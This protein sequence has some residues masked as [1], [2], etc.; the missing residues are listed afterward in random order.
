MTSPSV[1]TREAGT[2]KPTRRS[3]RRPSTA[4]I[5][6][7]VAALLAFGLNYLALQSRDATVLVAVA[8]GDIGEGTAFSAD[9]VRLSALPSSFEGVPHLILESDL[10][11]FEGWILTRSLSDGELVDRAIVVHP[12]ATGGRRTMSIPV[13]VEHAAGAT[14]V[15]GDRV[16]VISIVDGESLFVATDLEVVSVADPASGGLSG[17]E[18]YHI[19][20]AVTADEALEVAGAIAQGSVEL[21][22]STGASPREAGTG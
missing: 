22:R 19:V 4:H 14:V 16:D 18:P 3:V 15:A 2:S 21:V 20:V 17:A 5:L 12:G 11:R 9:L 10:K 6:I 1:L 7:V 8:D 13:G